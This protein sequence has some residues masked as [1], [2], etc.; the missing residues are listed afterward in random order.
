VAGRSSDT[1]VKGVRK[2]SNVRVPP[3]KASEE[4]ELSFLA[5]SDEELDEDLFISRKTVFERDLSGGS[6]GDF[7]DLDGSSDVEVEA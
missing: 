3:P 6:G 4:T 5:S 1:I 2:K 7:V